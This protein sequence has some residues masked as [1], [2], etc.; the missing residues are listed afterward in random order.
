MVMRGI[1]WRV[2]ALFAVSLCLALGACSSSSVGSYHGPVQ[3]APYARQVSAIKLRGRAAA[4]W[5]EARGHYPRS[6]KPAVGSV[7]VFKASKR[8]P[9]GHVSVVRRIRT[10]RQIEVDHANWV[11]GRIERHALVE[12]VSARGDWSLVRVW[13]APS[14]QMG[15]ERYPT[16]GF[17]LPMR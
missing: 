4:W 12:D 8:I 3:C 16:Y 5:W 2:M 9:N 15:R 1:T 6:H 17:I 11:G 7:L 13:W 14:G 10:Q